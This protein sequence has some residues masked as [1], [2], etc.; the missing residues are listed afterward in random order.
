MSSQAPKFVKPGSVRVASNETEQIPNVAF[1]TPDENV[2][3]ILQNSSNQEKLINI[4][5][6]E[7]V[8]EFHLVPGAVEP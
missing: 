1:L 6:G 4:N 5:V 2:V 3:V 7:K 8:A